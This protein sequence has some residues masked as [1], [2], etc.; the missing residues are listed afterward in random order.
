MSNSCRLYLISPPKLEPTSFAEVLRRAL[1]A[2]DVASLQ[3]RLKDVDAAQ[4]SMVQIAKDL[5][6]KGEIMLAGQGGDDELIY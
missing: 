4:M 5:A 6:A 2:G 1:G 3:L